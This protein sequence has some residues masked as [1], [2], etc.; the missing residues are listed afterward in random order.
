[1]AGT[2]QSTPSARRATG[3]AILIDRVVNISIHALREE[4][5]KFLL[6]LDVVCVYFNPRPPRGERPTTILTALRHLEFQSTPSA[7]RATCNAWSHGVAIGISIHALREESDASQR[8][9][10]DAPVQ[11][12]STPSARRATPDLC[13][14]LLD[15]LISIHALR[16]ESDGQ[17]LTDAQ[18]RPI[19]IHALREESDLLHL[20]AEVVL[21]ISIHALREESDSVRLSPETVP[22]NF[23][24]RPPRG[25]RH[26]AVVEL[27]DGGEISIHALREESDLSDPKGFGSFVEFQSTPSARRATL[28]SDGSFAPIKRFQST[29][30]ARRATSGVPPMRAY[31]PHFNPRPPRGERQRPTSWMPM[32]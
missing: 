8:S 10:P 6:L 3:L 27:G 23:N 14:S 32:L 2:F 12:Q 24:P 25:E 18:A 28:P 16:E 5:D 7:R 29:P 19:S 30:S 26:R 21:G 15:R 22:K 4:S 13:E 31:A 9:A 20:L 17:Q 1:M 11:F